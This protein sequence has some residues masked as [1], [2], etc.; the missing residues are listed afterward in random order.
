MKHAVDPIPQA[1]IPF[2]WLDVNVAGSRLDRARDDEVHHA[3]HGHFRREVAQMLDVLV[4][5]CEAFAERLDELSFG[6]VV[7]A[8]EPFQLFGDLR[9]GRK[10]DTAA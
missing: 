1:E 8:V 5:G 10:K 3:D 4:V 9:F 7:S 2:E 6:A